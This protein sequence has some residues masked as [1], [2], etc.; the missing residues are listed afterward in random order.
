MFKNPIQLTVVP[1]LVASQ[2]QALRMRGMHAA[3]VQSKKRAKWKLRG[4]LEASGSVH[5]RLEP[6]VW[7]PSEEVNL[8]TPCK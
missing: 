1:K 7:N 2:G 3:Q 4:K 6:K 8:C 5:C